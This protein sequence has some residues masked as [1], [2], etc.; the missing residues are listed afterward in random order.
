[1]APSRSV[2]L[3]VLLGA[4]TVLTAFIVADLLGT[5]FFG[6]T[7]AMVLIPVARWVQNRGLPRWWASVVATVIA[8]FGGVAVFLPIG[9]VLYIRREQAIDLINSIPDQFV[10]DA[11]GISYTVVTADVTALTIRYLRDLAVLLA[12]GTPL[13]VAQA[14]VFSFVIFGVLLKREAIGRAI[15]A[16]IPPEYHD[17][18]TSLHERF[19]EILFA[20][21]IIQAATAGGTFLVATAFFAALGYQFPI[22]LGVASGILQFLPVVGPSLVVLGVAAIEISAGHLSQAAIVAV[23]GI[24]LVAVLPDALIRPRLARETARLPASLYFVGFTGGLLSLGPVGV[25]AGPL[26]VAMLAE[27]MLLLADEMNTDQSWTS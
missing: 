14:F 7:V 9:I 3:A 2:A 19:R 20:L 27:L 24:V 11:F 18:A 6:L 1:M 25:I 23:L 21:Y 4:V 26:V 17:I 22:T 5:I 12:R 13:L 8:F 10:I 15:L 16:P